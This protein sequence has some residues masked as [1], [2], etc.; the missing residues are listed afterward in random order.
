MNIFEVLIEKINL[1]A[2]MAFSG[3]MTSG[4]PHLSSPLRALAQGESSYRT[5]LKVQRVAITRP[6]KK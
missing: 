6:E 3:S 4:E 1:L 2:R 5:E